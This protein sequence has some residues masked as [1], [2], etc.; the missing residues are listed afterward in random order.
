[1]LQAGYRPYFENYW[2]R[3]FETYCEIVHLCTCEHVNIWTCSLVSLCTSSHLSLSSLS[4]LL[5]LSSLSEFQVWRW[6]SW[7]PALQLG[8]QCQSFG[9]SN[10]R[11]FLIF[12]R[13]L[14]F[15]KW[16][17]VTEPDFRKKI[18]PAPQR[19]KRAKFG[20]K[21]HFFEL[22]G[23]LNHRIFLIFGMKLGLNKGYYLVKT[24]CPKKI[25]PAPQRA[26]SAR[27][28]GFFNFSRKRR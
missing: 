17:T 5:I 1:M 23:K 6:V 28:W 19:A 26:K 16:W 3:F 11:N 9:T 20:P 21:W 4:S 15:H 7:S 14:V 25:L 27:K 8:N 18:L 13:E 22:C 24:A 2:P 12:G 10:H